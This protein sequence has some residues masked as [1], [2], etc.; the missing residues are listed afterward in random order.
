MDNLGEWLRS[1]KTC[2]DIIK[3]ILNGMSRWRRGVEV[4]SPQ[5]LEFDDVH[6]IFESQQQIGWKPFMGRCI[7]IEWANVQGDYYKWIVLKK[8]RETL[9]GSSY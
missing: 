6:I 5:N 8:N 1:S 2:H 3:L 9:G 7:S 4:S